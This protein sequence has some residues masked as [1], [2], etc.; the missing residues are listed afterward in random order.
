ME[1]LTKSN[2]IVVPTHP[3]F[4]LPQLKRRLKGRYFDITEVMEEESL[5]V[6]NTLTQ[7]D[8]QDAFN[9]MAEA[10]GMVHTCESGLLQG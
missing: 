5:A 3:T 4:L 10:L 7:H 8:F 6:L 9:K 2:M 1:F